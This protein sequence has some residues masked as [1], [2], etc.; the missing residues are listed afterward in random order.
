[1]IDVTLACEDTNSKLFDVA[2]VADFDAR[3]CVDDT[4]VDILKLLFGIDFKPEY[5]LRKDIEHDVLSTF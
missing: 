5:L 1:M 2:S 4:L 3:E